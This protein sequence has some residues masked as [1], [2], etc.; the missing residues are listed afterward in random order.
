[1][2]KDTTGA[3]FMEETKY[4]YLQESDQENGFPQPA[5]EQPYL[6]TAKPIALPEIDAI[7]VPALDLTAAI[8]NRRSIREYRDEALTLDELAYLLWTTQGVKEI[9]EGRAT[10]RTVPSA[11]ARHPFETY[12][13]INNVSGLEPGLYRYLALSHE[14][15]AVDLHD[16]LKNEIS[17][18]CWRQRFVAASAVT[19]IWT[20][21]PYRTT[22]RYVERGYRYLYLDAGHV[23]ENLYLAAQAIDCGCCAIAAYDDDR[24]NKILGVDGE[25]EF[26][27]YVAPLGKMAK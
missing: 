17:D 24:L 4:K 23:C 6:G 5:L 3:R 12:L 22:W 8:Q 13:L 19:F 21:V 2:S 18:A 1:M 27:I 9:F 15:V 26:A 16:G 11:G 10:L 20:A 14:L 25:E 7:S